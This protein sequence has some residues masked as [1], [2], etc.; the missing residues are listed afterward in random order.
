ME[1][2]RPADQ[3]PRASKPFRSVAVYLTPGVSSFGLSI[4]SSV[5]VDRSRQ[6]LPRF[7]LLMCA[8]DTG[9]V[10][11]DLGW[12]VDVEHGPAAMAAAD[13]VIVPP[14]AQ[15]PLVLSHRAIDAIWKAHNRG[16]I[17]AAFCS[18][19]VLLAETGLLDGRPATTH[20]SLASHLARRRPSVRVEPYAPYVDAGDVVTGNGTAIGID[21]FLHLLQR[22]YGTAIAHAVVRESIACYTAAPARPWVTGSGDADLLELLSWARTRLNQP[23][24]VREMA[25]HASMSPRTFARRFRAA[26]G[27]TPIAWLHEQR[28]DQAEEL[29]RTTDKPI[30]TIAHEVGFQPGQLRAHFMKRHGVPPNAY[31]QSARERPADR[32]GR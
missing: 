1:L 21:M 12:R 29:L 16:S 15:R 24:S 23:L 20:R 10:H 2:R 9:V 17:V 22:E 25:R 14:T 6:G 3:G 27:T 13:L 5:F 18:G 31:R 32:R 28:L 11:T 4:V 19:S 8:D 30:S 7:D 26:L